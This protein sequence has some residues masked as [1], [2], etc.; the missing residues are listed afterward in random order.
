MIR[1]R[2]WRH[3][4]Q[5]D[6]VVERTNAQTIHTMSFMK[7]SNTDQSSKGKWFTGELI[8]HNRMISYLDGVFIDN[9]SE[10]VKVF[11]TIC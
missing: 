3:R 4:I 5:D 7:A 6:R 8:C 10:S 2:A 9:I 11:N 1:I